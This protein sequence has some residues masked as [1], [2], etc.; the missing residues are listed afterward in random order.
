MTCRYCGAEFPITPGLGECPKCHMKLTNQE[1]APKIACVCGAPHLPG[2]KFCKKCGKSLASMRPPTEVTPPPQ[3]AAEAPHPPPAAGPLP[4][5]ASLSS[6]VGD[7][8]TVPTQSAPTAPQAPAAANQPK[9][10]PLALAG[11]GV[12][13]LLLLLW[14]ATRPSS[15]APAVIA[16]PAVPPPPPAATSTVVAIQPNPDWFLKGGAITGGFVPT[17]AQKDWPEWMQ[18]LLGNRQGVSREE[19]ARTQCYRIPDALLPRALGVLERERVFTTDLLQQVT[20]ISYVAD[21]GS[22][23]L[24]RT[25]YQKAYLAVNTL[26]LGDPGTCSRLLTQLCQAKEFA[27]A[28]NAMQLSQYPADP[29]LRA[30][31]LRM[32]DMEEGL[33][34]AT[35]EMVANQGLPVAERLLALGNLPKSATGSDMVA[36]FRGTELFGTAV[37]TGL[38][39]GWITIS[40]PMVDEALQGE[41]RGEPDAPWF[42]IQRTERISDLMWLRVVDAL[43]AGNHEAAKASATTLLEQ[44]PNSYYS[45]HA[46]YALSSLGV[47]SSGHM[48]RLK[49]P[50]DVTLY[51]SDA[52]PISA[53]SAEWPS[54]FNELASKGRYDVILARADLATQP[55]IFLKAA[56]FA[57][58]QDLVGRYLS[59]EKKCSGDSLSWLYPTALLPVL[60]KLIQEEGLAGQVEP[61]FA[62]SVIKCESLFQ[63]SA[64]SSA[65]ASG[66]MQ[67]LKPTFGRIMGKQADL[68]D[69]LTNIRG[70]LRYFKLI[71]KTAGLEGLPKDV[72]Y[73]YILAGYHAGEGRAKSWRTANEAKLA[74]ATDPVHKLMRVEAVPIYSTRQYLTRVLGDYEMYRRLME[75]HSTF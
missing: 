55:Q 66:L 54:P 17:E 58:Q 12:L 48:P 60:D 70:G 14:A 47:V 30:S 73:A 7:L 8:V 5:P 74:N 36:T 22:W 1:T 59:I 53:P 20:S 15:P 49:V 68:R 3:P 65:D 69:P 62:L 19:L 4:P 51:N 32:L 10:L 44:F 9:A 40:D 52:L 71:I 13:V 57:G 46:I 45:G 28:R 50:S 29:G 34:K 38:G 2:A 21:T 18:A 37:F 33:L 27:V 35:P 26:P 11:G 31:Y 23:K 63:P 39:K 61:A 41:W 56:A 67:L 25:A 75:T 72:R 16:A 6:Q 42:L 43:N 24:A 64:S